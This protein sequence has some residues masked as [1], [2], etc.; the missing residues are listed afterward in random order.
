MK[1]K[2]IGKL[3]FLSIVF[4]LLAVQT[5]ASEPAFNPKEFKG[6]YV[7][8]NYLWGSCLYLDGKGNFRSFDAKGH[9]RIES[10]PDCNFKG[11]SS[12]TY[13][14]RKGVLQFITSRSRRSSR[15]AVEYSHWKTMV[16]FYSL[17]DSVPL[18]ASQLDFVMYPV[19]WS[20]RLYLLHDDFYKDFANAINLG[21]EPRR[22]LSGEPFYAMFHLRLGDETKEVSGKPTLPK[23]WLDFLLDAPIEVTVT[24]VEKRPSEYILTIDKG[25][26]TGLKVGMQLVELDA[27]EPSQSFDPIIVSVEKGSAKLRA[28]QELKVGI[29]LSTKFTPQP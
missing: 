20:G 3:L 13:F 11:G 17:N 1:F 21:L 12:G 6:L 23:E 22:T 26:E 14:Y 16:D 18:A 19:K 24:N 7:T 9:N 5:F 4:P 27:A 10:S 15:N 2:S 28:Q 29:K 8:G 25:S